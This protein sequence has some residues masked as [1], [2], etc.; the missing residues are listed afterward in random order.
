MDQILLEGVYADGVSE[1]ATTNSLKEGIDFVVGGGNSSSYEVEDFIAFLL[2][3][4]LFEGYPHE[5]ILSRHFPLVVKLAKGYSFPLFPYFLGTLYAHL[6]RFTLDLQRS[7]G[8]FQMETFVPIAI[9]Q[10]W[11]WVC[12][13]NYAP[14][15]KAPS[16][17]KTSLPS[18]RDYHDHSIGIR[19]WYPLIAS[20]T[21]C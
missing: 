5:R 20:F 12:F 1:K 8:R 21:R 13:K 18:P 17:F 3:R 15:P 7:W 16:S 2:S 11:V 14:V 4:H 10:I 6:D 19:F 9:L